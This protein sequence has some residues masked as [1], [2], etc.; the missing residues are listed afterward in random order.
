MAQ[1]PD[2]IRRAYES[3]LVSF[4]KGALWSG[5]AQRVDR[6]AQTGNLLITQDEVVFG[7]LL[8]KW[9]APL[10]AAI[11]VQSEGDELRLQFTG[12]REDLVW[13]VE[14]VELTVH[15][16]S[17]DQSIELTAENLAARLSQH[18]SPGAAAES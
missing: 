5:P 15:L 3:G 9:R 4:E 12:E 18:G 17:G 16:T 7:G 6:D 13:E 14:P 11:G 8:R 1:F 2:A 10:D